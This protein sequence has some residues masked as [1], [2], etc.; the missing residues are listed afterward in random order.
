MRTTR[1]TW[2]PRW[3][4]LNAGPGKAPSFFYHLGD[5][6]YFNGQ[7]AD[8]YSQ[9]YEPYNHY[10]APILAIPGNHDGDPIDASQ[11]SLDGWVRYFMTATSHVNSESQD[12]P[13]VTLSQPNVYFTLQCPFVTIV[14][15]YERAGI[16]ARSIRPSNSG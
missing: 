11:V 7:I 15:I 12:A 10:A 14:G 5:V 1:R 2:P 4:D 16:M 9:F 6:V 3:G 8:Y 13:R